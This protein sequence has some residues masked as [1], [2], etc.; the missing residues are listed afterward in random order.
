MASPET[1][2]E[3]HVSKECKLFKDCPF[4]WDCLYEIAL[5]GSAI[6]SLELCYDL[7]SLIDQG[8]VSM[9]DRTDEKIFYGM[10]TTF[11]ERS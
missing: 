1:E 2:Q 7:K 3:H 11:R 5:Y 10:L 4:C 9:P 6:W 8:L